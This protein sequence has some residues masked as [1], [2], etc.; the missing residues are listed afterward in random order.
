[1]RGKTRPGGA[2]YGMARPGTAGLGEAKQVKGIYQTTQ[3][4]EG[5]LM[6]TIGDTH[7]DTLKLQ[8]FLSTQNHGSVLTYEVVQRETGV[9]MDLIGKGRLR[10]AMKHLRREYSAIRGTGIRLAD[11]SGVLPIIS[12]RM[13]RIDN[14]V[15]RADKSQRNLQDQFYAEMSAEDKKRILFMGA[16]FGAIRL[17][18][19]QGRQVQ[20]ANRMLPTITIPLPNI[21]ESTGR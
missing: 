8:D 10:Q 7:Q 11:A 4:G 15:R 3:K 9:T 13:N 20:R 21:S 6:R 16:V 17:A 14:A 2:R 5:H 12:S 19:E 18:A 1:M